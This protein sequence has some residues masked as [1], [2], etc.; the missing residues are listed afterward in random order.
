M[1]PDDDGD[2]CAVDC[3]AVLG[4]EPS[5]DQGY[6]QPGPI[7]LTFAGDVGSV[8]VTGEGAILCAGT[9]GT[10]IGYDAAGALLGQVALRLID[11][12]DCSPSE[13]PDDVTFGATATLVTQTPMA[14]AVILPMSPLSFPVFGIPGGKAKATYAVSVGR[15]GIGAPPPEATGRVVLELETPGFIPTAR[16]FGNPAR[17]VFV[18]V[19]EADGSLRRNADISLNLDIVSASG[20]HNHVNPS[21]PRGTLVTS[22]NTG[23]AGRARVVY[24]AP[25]VAGDVVVTGTSVQADDGTLTLNVG[26]QLS[27]LRGTIP[28]LTYTGE[29]PIYPLN[30]FGQMEFRDDLIEF[31]RRYQERLAYYSQH[32]SDG[33]APGDR[34]PNAFG[35]NDFSLPRGGRF[36]LNQDWAG[37]HTS[38][39][40]G[41]EGDFDVRR[42]RTDDFLAGIVRD[43]WDYEM[44]NTYGEERESR[45][46]VHLK[47]G[48]RG[49]AAITSRLGPLSSRGLLVGLA[50]NAS[51]ASVQA[52]S[53]F[54]PRRDQLQ[55]TVQ[56]TVTNLGGDTVRISYR[57]SNSAGSAQAVGAVVVR[58]DVVPLSKS[59]PASWYPSGGPVADSA[60]IAWLGGSRGRIQP[61]AALGGMVATFVGLVDLVAYRIVG[62]TRNPSIEDLDPDSIPDPPTIWENGAKGVTL[63]VIPLPPGSTASS[64][65]ARLPALL[66]RT[67]D[68]GWVDSPGICNSLQVKL[69]AATRSL[70]RG[71]TTAARNELNAFV[72]E[73]RA[74]KSKHIST[75]GAT[76]LTQAAQAVIRRL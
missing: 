40:H 75:D 50:L 53:T 8:T 16:T 1:S 39:R 60:A 66:A 10:L 5:F 34:V 54:W 22:V 26:L 28:G 73:V 36:D 64:L 32:P 31:S 65:S 19:K 41:F 45:N 51:L 7:T 52:Q 38:H 42:G 47:L 57:V 71:N 29:K 63:G 18:S 74:Q 15:G 13:N 9:Y 20:G 6:D 69:D 35:A 48:A 25:E 37:P 70:A 21:R 72:K 44:K 43:I 17:G 33:P 58:T 3:V 14:R 23:A 76:L 67:C 56:P 59:G 46:H 30:E 61:G 24:H 62:D 55:V 4:A 68:L 27:N 12:T 11:P 49:I 2:T